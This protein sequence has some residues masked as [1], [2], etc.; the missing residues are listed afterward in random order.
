MKSKDAI[1][2]NVYIV[3]VSN[4]LVPVRLEQPSI[5][6]GWVGRNMKTGREVRIKTAA[7]LRCDITNEFI[8]KQGRM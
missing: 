8:S 2:G 3:K 7:K 1:L 6:G 4:N 5:Y